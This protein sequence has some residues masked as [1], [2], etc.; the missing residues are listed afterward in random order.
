MTIFAKSLHV[1]TVEYRQMTKIQY[2]SNTYGEQRTMTETNHLNEI[3]SRMKLRKLK[4]NSVTKEQNALAHGN[5]PLLI[6]R[7]CDDEPLLFKK[8]G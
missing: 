2:K 4:E 7:E 5:K 3:I 8:A 1:D 6:G